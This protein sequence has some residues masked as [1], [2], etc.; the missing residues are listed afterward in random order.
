MVSDSLCQEPCVSNDSELKR[1]L[2]P[3]RLW[4]IAVGLVISG[5]YFGWN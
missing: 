3:L 2:T 4:A 1:V 5:D